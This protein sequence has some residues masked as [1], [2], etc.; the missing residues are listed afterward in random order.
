MYY[1]NGGSDEVW[2]LYLKKHKDNRKT[3]RKNMLYTK[4]SCYDHHVY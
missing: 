2:C 3:K 4:F 1:C